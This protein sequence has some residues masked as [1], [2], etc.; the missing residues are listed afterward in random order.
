MR[1]VGLPPNP[2]VGSKVRAYGDDGA[3]SHDLLVIE[4][5]FG[6]IGPVAVYPPVSLTAPGGWRCNCDESVRVCA[7]CLVANGLLLRAWA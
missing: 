4:A 2:R 6:F 3:G 5:V 1:A 7:H